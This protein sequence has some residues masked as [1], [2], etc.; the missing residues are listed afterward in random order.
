MPLTGKERRKYLEALKEKNVAGEH[1]S[2][3]PAG[4][5]LRKGKKDQ[6][7]ARETPGG[8]ASGSSKGAV[9]DVTDLAVSPPKKK[10]R[11]SRKDV[12]KDSQLEKDAI[13]E[14]DAAYRQSFWHRDFR[15]RQYMEANVPF[16]AVDEDASFHAKF[17]E[18]A[19]DAGTGALRSLVYMY[20]MERKY[21]VL[22][23]QLQEAVKD[24]EK[25]K[26]QAAAFEERVEGLLLDKSKA[27]EAISGLELEKTSWLSEKG[28]FEEKV[29]DLEK[30]LTDAKDEV[31]GCKMAMVG[32]FE[33]GFERA[34]MQV[35]F[36][37]P[38][39]DL[40]ALDSLKIVQ[41]GE[42]IDEP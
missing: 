16:A 28:V 4:L 1:I 8:D 24:V 19:Q 34:K 38:E 15:Y 10:V 37:Y 25:H 3:D 14:V 5:L 27:E 21:D 36:L 29:G 31:E 2:S 12:G 18:L 30:Q 7:S 41:D 32:Q 9:E 17:S 13:A 22:E 20:A 23:K 33:E 11:S 35:A 6:G 26:H 40:F 42:L 39:L